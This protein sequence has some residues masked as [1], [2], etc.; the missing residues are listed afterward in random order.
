MCGIAGIASWGAPVDQDVVR[1]MGDALRHR[2]PDDA[3]LYRAPDGRAG[4]AHR[5]LSIMDLSPAGRQPMANEAGTIWLTFNGEI[6]NF[7]DLRRDLEGRGHRF[8]SRTDSEVILHAYE[9]WGE[10]CVDRLR[11]MFAFALWDEGARRL[12]LARDRLGIKPLLYA[13]DDRRLAFASE[14]KAILEHPGVERRLDQS[15]LSDYL[16]YLYIPSPKTAYLSVRKLP[17]AHVLVADAGGIRLKPYWDVS[18]AAAGLEPGRAVTL[19]REKLAEAVPLHLA[20]DVPVGVLLSGGMDSSTV[21]AALTAEGAKGL[22]SFS[23]DFDV[24]AHSEVAYA[25]LAAERFGTAH[26]EQVVGKESV[27]TMLA[28]T[29]AMYDEPFGDGS[30][31]PTY[32]V[33]RLAAAEVKVVLSGDGGDEVFAGYDWYD[34]WLRLRR[35]DAVPLPLRRALFRPLAAAT[36][37]GSKAWR[38]LLLPT[39]DPLDQYGQLVHLFDPAEKARLLSPEILRALEGYDD[40]WHLRAFWRED[41][42]PLSRLQYVDLKTYLPDDILTKVDRASMA[43]SLEVRPPLLDHEVVELVATFPPATRYDG[44]ER[45]AILKAAMG[46]ALPEPILRRRKKGF[47]AP[48]KPWLRGEEEALRAALREGEGARR[49]LLSPAAFGPDSGVRLSGIRLWALLVLDE[50]LSQARPLA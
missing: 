27:P 4:L 34:R 35:W 17:P 22:R 13:A 40:Y 49:G 10:T 36:P 43:V 19:L 16:T 9:E 15:A 1:A 37:M 42:D 50:W 38:S 26:R 2:G 28:R 30:A 41:L 23:I 48:L 39:R 24:V 47:S 12:I 11:G 7:P 31:I 3:G 32:F 18:F 14:L 20:S 33:S 5:R 21:L 29:V 45:K 25:R 44:A 6:Y 8:R 46:P